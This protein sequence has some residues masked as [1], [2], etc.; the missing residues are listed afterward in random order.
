MRAETGTVIKGHRGQDRRDVDH[1]RDDAD[2]REQRSE[3]LAHRLLQGLG[4][5]VDV[6]GDPAEQLA[7]RG[8]VEVGKR[9]AAKLRLDVSPHR[10]DGALHD[11]R[12]DAALGPGQE[13]GCD[14]QHEND[15]QDMA[16]D[17]EVDA[18]PRH[19]IHGRDHVRDL[20]LATGSQPSDRLSLCHPC[21]KTPT[22]QTGEDQVG[23][24]AHHL[25]ADDRQGHADDR[26]RAR[27]GNQPAVAAQPGDQPAQRHLE[28]QGL[29]RWPSTH[30]AHRAPWARGRPRARGLRGDTHAA[31]SS[32]S[33]DSTICR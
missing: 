16:D 24:G 7:G 25:G 2:D 22:D 11:H 5:V 9:H 3:Q 12:H 28:V 4:D 19:H 32:L 6:V 23:G 10:I 26:E 20:A 27:S 33:W 15:Q 21:R 31:S 8:G 13:R 14:I 1:H 17:G 30:V 29:Y 18:T